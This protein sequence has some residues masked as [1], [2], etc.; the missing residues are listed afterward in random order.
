MNYQAQ[1]NKSHYE[2]TAYRSQERWNSYW[3]Q[4]A[5]VRRTNPKTLLEVGVG[6]GVVARELIATGI[7]VTTVD[8][9]EDLHPDVVGSITALPFPDAAFD[10]VLAAEILE[11]IRFEDVPQALRELVRVAR[12]SVVISV[13]HPGYVFSLTGKFPL[14]P[15][16]TLMAQIPFFWKKHHFTGEHYWELGKSGYSIGRFLKLAQEAGLSLVVCEKHAD[17]PGHRF[18]YF[19][20]R[21][22]FL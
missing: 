5:L 10:T 21:T 20:K 17:D 2:G 11:N 7:A 13:P 1:V 12:Y 18:F 8:I 4:I 22:I 16:L 3:H 19:K 14:L 9:A 15:L 6:E